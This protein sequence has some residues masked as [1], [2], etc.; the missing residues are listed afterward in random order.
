MKFDELLVYRRSDLIPFQKG[1]AQNENASDRMFLPFRM[2]C[3]EE[4]FA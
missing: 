4:R 1:E 2:M 3:L